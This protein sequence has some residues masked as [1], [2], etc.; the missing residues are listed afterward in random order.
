MS[1][2]AWFRECFE[3]SLVGMRELL[4]NLPERPAE[5]KCTCGAFD[6]DAC[7]C[8]APEGDAIQHVEETVHPA[9]ASREIA[10][11][12]AEVERQDKSRLALARELDAGGEG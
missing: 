10:R 7:A 8:P 12:R 4:N 1:G 3:R 6:P 5:P 11:L 2:D 9:D